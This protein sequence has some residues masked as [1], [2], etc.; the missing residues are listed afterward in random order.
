[1][2]V[3]IEKVSKAIR[4]ASP[5]CLIIVDGIQH[6]A[7]GRLDIDS[8]NIDGYAISPYKV[9]SRHG[10]GIAWISNT[11]SALPHNSLEG[12]PD[13]NWELGTRDSGAY[14]TFSGGVNYFEWLGESFTESADRREKIVAAGKAIHG[15]EMALTDAMIHGTGNLTG[16]AEMPGIHIIGGVDNHR[17]EGLVAIYHDTMDAVDLVARLSEEGIRVHV[18]KDDHYSGNILKP[19]G[20]PACVRVSLCHYNTEHEVAQFLAAMA[21]ITKV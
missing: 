13:G 19:L 1:M 7:H 4:A 14:A 9:F 5:D 8:Y 3:D 18:R 16:L 21:E 17:R 6:A 10:Y 20:L 11:L 2:A 15:H 12:G